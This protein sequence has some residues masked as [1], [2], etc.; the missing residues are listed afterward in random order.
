MTDL[1]W[2][3]AMS[4]VLHQPASQRLGVAVD[5]QSRQ[6]HTV[7]PGQGAEQAVNA[8]GTPCLQDAALLCKPSEEEKEVF[9]QGCSAGKTTAQQLTNSPGVHRRKLGLQGCGL[10]AAARHGGY[11][12]LGVSSRSPR[13]QCNFKGLPAMCTASEVSGELLVFMALKRC[14]EDIQTETGDLV[15]R[16]LSQGLKF[17]CTDHESFLMRLGLNY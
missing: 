9:K 8:T 10:V 7:A 4:S 5:T 13:G 3:V 14:P 17:E 12:A 1:H 16:I 2:W 11:S 15:R 6:A